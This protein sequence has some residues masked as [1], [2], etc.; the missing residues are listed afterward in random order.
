[1]HR[2]KFPKAPAPIPPQLRP[3]REQERRRESRAPAHRKKR[4]SL[5]AAACLAALLVVPGLA[6]HRIGLTLDPR[7]V[8][9]W[10]VFVSLITAWLYRYDKRQAEAGGWRTPE[11]TLHLAELCGGW[12]AAFWAQRAFRHKITKPTYQ[13]TY[14]LIVL[15]HET[16]AFDFLHDWKYLH[17]ALKA[18]DS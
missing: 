2:P 8:L 14:W 3:A 12:P 5:P 6:L 4:F 18:L 13:F 7:W 9:G 1:M 15:L 10:L 16:A 11:S 17:A